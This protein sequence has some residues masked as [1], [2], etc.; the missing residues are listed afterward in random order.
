M[1]GGCAHKP[2]AALLCRS[3]LVSAPVDQLD[4]IL[5]SP[6]RHISTVF[7][8]VWQAEQLAEDDGDGAQ[9]TR[10]LGLSRLCKFTLDLSIGG[11][12]GGNA[13]TVAGKRGGASGRGAG[14]QGRQAKEGGA[15]QQ[16]HKPMLPAVVVGDTD[17]LAAPG[18][19]VISF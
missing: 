1:I 4:R 15:R 9:L 19:G 17:A 11:P 2:V 7:L 3:A 18:E 6:A 12:L 8:D 14:E 5:Q 16:Q 13:S 10:Q